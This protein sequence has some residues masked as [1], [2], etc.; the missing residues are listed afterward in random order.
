MRDLLMKGMPKDFDILT[1]ATVAQV[2]SHAFSTQSRGSVKALPTAT[3][4]GVVP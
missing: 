2:R 3:Q 4:R 1:S